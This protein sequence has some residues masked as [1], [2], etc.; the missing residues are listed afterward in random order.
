MMSDTVFNSVS[1]QTFAC[2]V[3]E[4]VPMLE[5]EVAADVDESVVELVVPERLTKKSIGPMAVS[6]GWFFEFRFLGFAVEFF[7]ILISNAD[8]FGTSW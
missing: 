2:L 1:P 4:L 6:L 5:D 8:V 7:F 3:R